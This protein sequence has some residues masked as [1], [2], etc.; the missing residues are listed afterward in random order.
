MST[1]FR[2]LAPIRMTDLFD[3]R[4]NDVGVHEQH[5]EERR[6]AF[7][8]FADLRLRLRCAWPFRV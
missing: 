8:V 6:A 3:G 1:D 5:S 4:L 2:P 7:L